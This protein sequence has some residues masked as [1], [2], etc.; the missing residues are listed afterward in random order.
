[1]NTSAVCICVCTECSGSTRP[2]DAVF[3]LCPFESAWKDRHLCIEREP[4]RE[5]E[6]KRNEILWQLGLKAFEGCWIQR[7]AV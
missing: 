3:L 5:G 2:H 7:P 4:A 1:M 6:D